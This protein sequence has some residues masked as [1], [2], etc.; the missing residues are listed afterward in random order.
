MSQIIRNMRSIGIDL[1]PWVKKDL[2]RF[3][4][5][6]PTA[7]GLEMHLATMHKLIGEFKPSVVIV[8]P[9]TNLISVGGTNE[10]H[11]AL[12]RLIDFLKAEQITS[13]FTSLSNLSLGLEQT[14]VGISSMMDTWILL[15]DI[16]LSGE[17]NRGIYVL[18]SRGMAHSNQIREFHLSTQ[19]VQLT[20]VYVGPAGV[21][22]G[23]ARA[24]QEAQERA[25]AIARRQE[26]ERKQRELERK[27][28]A[29][30]AQ[31]AALQA[32]FNAQEEE[33]VKI[34]SQEQMREQSIMETRA[35]MTQIRKADNSPISASLEKNSHKVKS[36]G[37]GKAVQNEK[38]KTAR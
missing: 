21:L 6:R 2:L 30:E 20:D 19:G 22:T 28:R 8:D 24:A 3:H 10:V 35:R 37:N 4:A 27:R 18:K 12:V 38:R 25:E 7:Y 29:I 9:V 16:E 11:A 13:L 36:G 23:A 1:Q 17:R 14:D 15:R 32:E 26:I 5:V 33:V 31:I 34:I